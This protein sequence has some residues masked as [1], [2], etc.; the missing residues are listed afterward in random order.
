MLNAK[1]ERELC[2]LIKVDDIKPIEG[3]DFT[4][5]AVVGGWTIMV[6]KGQFQPGDIGIYFE[7]DSKVPETEPFLFLAAKHYKIKTQKYKT[8]SGHF[9]SQG[10]LMHPEDFGFETYI[11]GDGTQ[12]V[13]INGKS[14]CVEDETRFLTKELG[15]TYAE[16]EDNTRKANSD[17]NAKYKA[18]AARHPKLFKKPWVRWMMKRDWGKKIMFFFFGKK[19]DKP[20]VWPVGK[21][22][23]VAKTD[24]E[25]CLI[26]QTKILTDRGPMQISTIVNQKLPVEVA[27]MNKDGTISYK[28]I[29]DYQKFDNNFE[30]VMTIGYPAKPDTHNRE[31]HICCTPDHRFWT[32]RGYVEAKELTL[33]DKLFQAECCFTD[34][35]LGALYGTLLG[36][37]HI[38]NDSRS[39]GRLRI[40]SSN[41]E[42]QLEYLQ[43]KQSLFNNLGKIVSAGKGNYSKK[44]GYHWY[45]PVD[46]YI[47]M[48]VRAD[49]YSSGHKQ[50][51]EQALSKL[52]YCGLALWYMDDGSLSYRQSPGHSPSIRLNTQG[53]SL[54][55][56]NMIVEY[57]N[58]LG[59]ECN[60]R[61]DKISKDGTK[62]FYIVYITTK[63]T[64]IFLERI[65]PYMCQSMKYKTLPQ[66][67]HLI[68]TKKPCYTQITRAIEVPI[69]SI[70]Y[71]QKKSK[72]FGKKFKYVYDLEVE[73]NHNFIADSVI[74]HNCENMPW[75]LKDKTPFIVTQKCDGSSATYILERKKYNKF[76][77]YVCSRNVRM[78]NADQECFYGNRNY[79]WE[80]AIKYDIENKMRD[81]LKNNPDI[82]FICWQGEICAPGIQSNPHHLKDTHFYCFHMT[83]SKTGRFD[84]REAKKIWEKYNMEVVPIVNENYIM[85]DDFE[86]FKAS[87]DGFYDTSVCEDNPNCPREGFVYYKT[88]EPTF[89]FKNVSR[90]Y[91]SKQR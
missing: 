11:D 9:Y 37:G 51:T 87:A 72:A 60:I 86:E 53:F 83:D 67:E 18:I 77:F 80:V 73:D 17:P 12:Y 75:V 43:Y 65:T 30:E 5:C 28:K 45:L 70:E 29:L 20:N 69:L 50:I 39:K 52:N 25:R 22:P 15:V 23:G 64:P 40:Y 58:R 19:K 56:N 42:E 7:V 55:E 14:H 10:L 47:S 8:P 71:G 35:A 62:T 68:E 82:S 88:T 3:K 21:F 57:L 41:G 32:Q 31:N 79:Y 74:V 54:E 91:L 27:S 81:Y 63:G 26:G 44:N 4:E 78:M 36:D 38:G 33:Q 16:A 1:Q 76:E 2:Y 61:K 59:I 49:L 85:P 89:S 84:I 13:H 46:G 34:D 6:R 90:E 66:Y 48:N 24:Q